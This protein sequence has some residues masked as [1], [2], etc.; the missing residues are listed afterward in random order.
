MKAG[1]VAGLSAAPL[2]ALVAM[3]NPACAADIDVTAAVALTRDDNLFR[4]SDSAG[5]AAAYRAASL[6][7]H[8]DLPVSAQHL[9]ADGHYSNYR[10]QRFGEFDHDA[11]SA[12]LAW[13]WKA[14]SRAEGQLGYAAES[15]LTSI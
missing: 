7:A 11:W 2:L 4:Q 1:G 8:V 3:G 5:A 14:G 12:Q 15:T 6:G 13:Q 10:F 9:V